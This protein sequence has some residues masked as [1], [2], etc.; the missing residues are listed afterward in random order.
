MNTCQQ[1]PNARSTATAAR[2]DDPLFKAR[3]LIRCGCDNLT[4]KQ[5]ALLAAL[6][7]GHD[8]TAAVEVTW[9]VYQDIIIAYRHPE[10]AVGKQFLKGV[11]DRI[12]TGARP[13]SLS[14]LQP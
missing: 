10:P 4:D 11:I 6:W 8:Q 3:R 13:C 14:R 7:H 12:H 1:G 9:R 2:K 5:K